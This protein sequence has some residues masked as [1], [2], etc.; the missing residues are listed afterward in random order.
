MDLLIIAIS[1]FF[2]ILIAFVLREISFKKQLITDSNKRTKE[3]VK[4]L[5]KELEFKLHE[6]ER[7]R[8]GEF[9][10]LKTILQEHKILTGELK[11]STE[12]LK[13]VLS[14]NQSRGKWGEEIAD[15]LLK[16]IGFVSGEHYIS[17]T[18]QETNSNRPDFTI[19]LPD[20]KKLNI[21][22]KFPYAALVKFEETNDKKYLADFARDV[23]QKVKEVSSR[24]YINPEENTVDFVILFV[25]NE[26]IF[27]YIYDKLGDVWKEALKKKVVIAGPFSFTAILRM[28][29]QSYKSFMY[30]E[31]LGE[32]INLIKVF[33]QEYDKFN[34]ELDTLGSKLKTVNDQYD[35]V[36]VTRNKKLT[37]IVD[38][39][40]G[41]S[42]EAKSI[43]D[44]DAL[45]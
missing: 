15:S 38:K 44:Q 16:N 31:N 10:A 9:N 22:V 2:L 7:E 37:R 25:P 35:K 30:Y 26:R 20:K 39:I 13:N 42:E 3:E 41:E 34:Q 45:E 23:K 29:Y 6:A 28:V 5:I 4:E 8:L 24:D 32:I 33:E 27:S 1:A 11:E 17:N 40:K 21:D 43:S 18:A 12:G 14:N 19:F 36:S